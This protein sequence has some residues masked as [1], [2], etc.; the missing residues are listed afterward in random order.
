MQ[1]EAQKVID[2]N[3]QAPCVSLSSPAETPSPYQNDELIFGDC[4]VARARR[5]L[6]RH[7]RPVEVG[8]RAFD[9]LIALMDAQGKVLTKDQI[10]EQVWPGRIVEE[11]TL[12]GQ[13]SLLRRALGED[14]VAIRTIAGRGYQFVGELR[15]KPAQPEQASIQASMRPAEPALPA[16]HAAV[17]NLPASVSKLIGREVAL[18]EIA[19][20][21][22]LNRLI[23]LVGT[24]GIGKTRLA[25]ESARRIAERFPDGVF[26]VE[27]GSV[28]SPE[29]VPVAVALALGLA[30]GDGT[31]SLDR[32]V[33]AM[34]ARKLLLVI[35][36]C[37]HLIDAVA[38]LV[39]RLL[40][41]APLASVIATS[42][43]ALRA[44]GEYVYRVASLEIPHDD[45]AD[46]GKLM[47]YGALQ[48]FEARLGAYKSEKAPLQ[49]AVLKIRI[50]RRLD[51]IPL[52]LELA[53]ARV[54][55]L[56]LQ[57]V[58]DR[59][60]DR[61][62]LLTNGAR[63]ALPRQQTLRATLD[64]S[65]DLLP[66][67]ER[68][69]L[70]RLSVFA[71][72]FSI[73]DAQAVAA[74]QEINPDSVFDCVANLVSK[75]LISPD[76]NEGSTQFRLL[77][78][79]RVYAREKLIAEGGLNEASLRHAAYFQRIFVSCEESASEGM[80][81]ECRTR[82]S[83]HLEDFR[84]AVTWALSDGSNVDVGVNLTVSW[85]PLALQLGLLE[86]CL[87][88]VDTALSWI[89][90]VGASIDER[91]MKLYAARGAALLY[92]TGGEQTGVAFKL[93]LDIADRIGNLE[94][95][96]RGVWGYW[97]Y[98]YL[99]G[100]YGTAL[101]LAHRFLELSSADSHQWD[102][103]VGQ[104][105]LGITHLCLGNLAKSRASLESM[106]AG[107]PKNA[108]IEHRIRFL[109]DE[110]MLAHASLAQTLWLS[111]FPD[112]AMKV[113]MDAQDEAI[114]LDHLPS[115]C[116]ALSEAVCV[117]SLLN[118]DNEA[119]AR[120][121]TALTSATRQH[122][123]STWKARARMWAALESLQQGNLDAYDY[124]ILPALS[125]IGDA[126]FFIS[127]CPFLSGTSIA[128]GKHGRIADG[129]SLIRPAIARAQVNGDA[130]SLVELC[131]ANAV[132]LLMQGG[133]EA[134]KCAEEQLMAALS[135]ASE[136]HF[137]GWELRCAVS[138][139]G[140]WKRQGKLNSSNPTL[141]A[142]VGKFTEGYTTADLIAAADLLKA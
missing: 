103:L 48:M 108:S 138:L 75:S 67:A 1:S 131:R 136:Q 36:N 37:E 135:S 24:G 46:P 17:A 98:S 18:G 129:L 61:F 84:A 38:E 92:R 40:R 107:H 88:R 82:Y 42:R 60:L 68:T 113:A 79:T 54:P 3:M 11:N 47:Q 139:A 83:H 141:K 55:V 123:V 66:P 59:L 63:T 15:R 32:I 53:A 71:N 95:Q 130:T 74:S 80:T 62:Q 10:M 22:L 52:A 9:L 142:V 97:C 114:E 25:I 39:D 29:F 21:A 120:A 8:D 49:A 43:E 87:A 41:S 26:L 70:G 104:R 121:N 23:T 106:L 12:E 93:A 96:K 35:D 31:A 4:S 127:L 78:T 44:D 28:K 90:P 91:R 133:L 58:A 102:H 125:E 137:L 140:V 100:Q 77:E 112:Q 89:D 56:G 86:E 115:L 122:G 16:P 45:N 69:V 65:Y 5:R 110:K 64:W 81:A 126:Q 119:L 134:E 30:P 85:L 99:N 14:R 20:L 6:A 94:Y 57:G 111:G 27:L 109:Y 132:L 19:E 76:L 117:I 73:E 72:G 118:G 33:S 105:I 13:I 116:F 7:D 101:E 128:L 2:S 34:H 50:C 124:I 51:G